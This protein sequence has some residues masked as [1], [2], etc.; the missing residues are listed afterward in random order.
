MREQRWYEIKDGLLH[1]YSSPFP[2]RSEFVSVTQISD[3][4]YYRNT[5]T[6]RKIWDTA[7]AY[8]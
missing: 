1:V 5:F 4:T 2:E 8:V 3:L 7:P 6:L